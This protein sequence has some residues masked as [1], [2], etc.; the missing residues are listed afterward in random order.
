MDH[1]YA[2]ACT[3]LLVISSLGTYPSVGCPRARSA[4]LE[5]SFCFGI[6]GWCCVLEGFARRMPGSRT[7]KTDPGQREFSSSNRCKCGKIFSSG[8][9]LEVGLLSFLASN[10]IF[11][12]IH[13][14]FRSKPFG[15]SRSIGTRVLIDQDLLGYECASESGR[16]LL[17]IPQGEICENSRESQGGGKAI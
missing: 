10:A 17:H 14:F 13:G 15:C 16:R 2:R 5:N 3:V 4:I 12:T 8:C 9:I 7:S 6:S 1:Q 11:Q